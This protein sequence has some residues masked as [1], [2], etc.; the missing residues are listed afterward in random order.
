MRQ[1][2]RYGDNLTIMKKEKSCGAIVYRVA[3]GQ[4]HVLLLRPRHGRHWSFPKGHM[5]KDENEFETAVR[6][7]REETGLSISIKK[8][9]RETI[10]YRPK[11]SVLKDVVYF[12]AEATSNQIKMQKTEIGDIRWINIYD[13]PDHVTHQN[14]R[15]LM[16]KA[17]SFLKDKGV[18]S[19]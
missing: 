14:D 17:T 6:E 1:K 8:G 3:S 5:E 12:V 9:F 4:V 10:S 11:S 16:Y 19:D 7:V 15:D 18:L 13:A 2:E